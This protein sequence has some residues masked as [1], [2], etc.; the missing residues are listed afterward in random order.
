M[1]SRCI[2]LYL[3][4][5]SWRV[6]QT[7]TDERLVLSGLVDQRTMNATCNHTL[8]DEE[9]VCFFFFVFF[10]FPPS[11]Y[12]CGRARAATSLLNGDLCL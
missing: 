7:S 5:G 1:F 10:F 2:F 6:N 4:S 3:L 8:A 12:S 9:E 11:L